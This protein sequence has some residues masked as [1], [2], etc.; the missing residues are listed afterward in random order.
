[1]AFDRVFSRRLQALI[2]A[3]GAGLVLGGS[4]SLGASDQPFP[5]EGTW[6]RTDRVCNAQAPLARTYTAR[7]V[8][9]PGGRCSMRRIV[10]GSGEFELFED[11]R[12]S[13]HPG[14]AI[15]R[16]RMVSPDLMILK[17][18]INRLKIPRGRRY[19]RCSIAAPKVAPP[20]PVGRSFAPQLTKP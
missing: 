18:Q 8:I 19:A 10:Y 12:K 4:P 3:L 11:C 15:E 7:E 6:V 16:I 2:A 9:T 13:D 5:F 14:D 20:A 1:M 17:R